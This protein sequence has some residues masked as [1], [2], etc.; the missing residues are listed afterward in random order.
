MF[1]ALSE[2]MQ[3]IHEFFW[4]LREVSPALAAMRSAA[5]SSRPIRLTTVRTSGNSRMARS[6]VLVILKASGKGSPGKRTALMAQ[7]PSRNADPAEKM[8]VSRLG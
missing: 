7:A 1:P 4:M 2:I 6:S 8:H 3:L 5:N